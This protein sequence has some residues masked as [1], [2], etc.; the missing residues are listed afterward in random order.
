MAALVRVHQTARRF[1]L[2]YNVFIREFKIYVNGTPYEVKDLENLPKDLRPSHAST[3]GN[4]RVVVFF[5]K[6]SRFSNH[7]RST[8]RVDYTD[9]DSMEQFLALSRARF[10]ND[11]HL[12]DKALSSS[13]PADAKRILNLLRDAPGQP[14]WE[15]ERHDILM[16][17]LLAKFRQ[18]QD[19]KKYLLSSEDR[20]LGEASKN[21]T[22]GIGMSLTDKNRLN[23]RYWKGDNLL[24]RS[25]MEVRQILAAEKLA[26]Q[27]LTEADPS[28]AGQQSS[29][30][31]MELPD[32]STEDPATEHSSP[33]ETSPNT[34]TD[35]TD[36]EQS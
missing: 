25:L 21:M 14:E 31:S 9:F 12:I 29:L 24:G 11:Q 26:E 10:A 23:T 16:S 27:G 6:D 20:Q 18:N 13:D 34:S 8:F 35:H 19:L 32:P 4:S 28:P 15:E 30:P 2:K 7:Y 17:G 5:G 3:P 22:W 36:Q 33:P 1:P